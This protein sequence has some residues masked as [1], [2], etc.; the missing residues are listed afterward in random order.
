MNVRTALLGSFFLL[1]ACTEAPAPSSAPP[2]LTP[3]NGA[4]KSDG[5]ALLQASDRDHKLYQAA[6]N[7]GN[8]TVAIHVLQKV[9]ALDFARNQTA[10]FGPFQAQHERWLKQNAEFVESV[11][12]KP[13]AEAYVQAE[14][15]GTAQ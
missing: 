12:A 4:P 10:A 1:A 5:T 3:A 11:T 2:T 13:Q 15:T 8:K 14:V 6:L 9:R 7:A